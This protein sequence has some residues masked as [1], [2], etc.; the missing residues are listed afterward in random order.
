MAPR[1]I[2]LCFQ[3]A[4]LWE[5][6]KTGK[7]GLPHGVKRVSRPRSSEAAQG[8]LCAVV[9]PGAEGQGFSAYV[10]DGG[11]GGGGPGGAADGYEL[12]KAILRSRAEGPGVGSKD[13]LKNLPKGLDN[14]RRA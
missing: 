3:T 11:R 9:E 1:L 2:E 14:V 13:F 8:R 6:G 12:T 10:V 5:L 4:G 7:L